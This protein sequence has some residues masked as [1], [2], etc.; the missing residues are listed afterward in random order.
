VDTIHLLHYLNYK[1]EKKK[2]KK[3]VNANITYTVITRTY[4]SFKMKV[5]MIIFSPSGVLDPMPLNCLRDFVDYFPLNL[6]WTKIFFT[7][8]ISR[9]N[10][11]NTKFKKCHFFYILFNRFF[12][13]LFTCFKILFLT[14]YLLYLF[15]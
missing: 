12:I 6:G 10:M 4:Y 7:K 15:S 1:K 9:N 13:I 3:S 14:I 11:Q 5:K 8:S 2:K